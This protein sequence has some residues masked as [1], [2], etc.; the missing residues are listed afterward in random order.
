MIIVL[1][2]EEE[3]MLIGA[4][5][6]GCDRRAV[7]RQR[8]RA[9]ADGLVSPWAPKKPGQAQAIERAREGRAGAGRGSASILEPFSNS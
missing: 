8:S 9:L 4:G 7:E 1:T 3:D 5:V 6:P 2:L